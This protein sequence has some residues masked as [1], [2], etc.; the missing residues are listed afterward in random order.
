MNE[1]TVT[2]NGQSHHLPADSCLAELLQ[3]AGV[4]AQALA[5]A[6]NGEFVPRTQRAERRLQGGDVV[7][8]F[9]AIV[10]G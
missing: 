8:G 5:T 9:Q 3:K 10:G 6:V 2:L 7:L 4:D 1:I